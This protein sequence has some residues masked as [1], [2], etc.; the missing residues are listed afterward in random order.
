MQRSTSQTVDLSVQR[1]GLGDPGDRTLTRKVPIEAPVSIE[2]CGIGYAVMMATPCNLHDYLVGFAL[3]EGLVENPGQI[4][5][6]AISEVEGGWVARMTLPTERAARAF[7][8]ARQRVTESSCG[9][10]GMDN[11]EEVLRPLPVL[12]SRLSTDRTAIAKA[13]A[14]LRD[15]QDLGR[16]TGAAH[17]AA[18]C[19]PDG[20]I[21][22]VREDVGRHN[23]LDKLI[24]ALAK[25]GTDPAIGFILLSARCSYELVEK[26]VRA[27]CPML[28]T[29]SA[30]TSLAVERAKDARLTLVTLARSDSALI[31]TDENGIIE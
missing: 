30:P 3:C 21:Q 23:A 28:V 31:V 15:H 5:H 29:I 20:A 16:A 27:G 6:C 8:R 12:I 13:L 26:T 19:G 25:E 1:I 10:C 22:K 9:L 14:A 17:A 24:G 18:F 11:I 2:V 4:E 7:E